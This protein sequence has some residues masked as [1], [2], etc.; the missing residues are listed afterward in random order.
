MAVQLDEAQAVLLEPGTGQ[1]LARPELLVTE[2]DRV[3]PAGAA[4][5]FHRQHSDA[6]FVLEGEVVF[7]LAGEPV[8]A[9]AGTFVLS[10][11]GAVHGFRPPE[12]RFLNFHAP[13]A[14]YFGRGDTF[15][16]PS[17]VDAA[18]PI[19]L[20]PGGG[21]RLL[22][23]ERVAIVKAGLPELT[24]SV[25]EVSPDFEGPEPHQHDDHIDSFYVLDGEI[26]FRVE[27]QTVRAG[28]GFFAAL[29]PGTVHTFTRP[30]ANGARLLNMHAP[31]A[32]FLDFLRAESSQA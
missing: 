2:L 20:A 9:G 19:V 26:E 31:D 21:E 12:G 4:Q 15:D 23:D 5:H 7:E 16:P 25:F 30:G 14:P 10:P 22:G 11:P 32:S 8:P 17:D 29:L 3:P 6:F 18:D 13:G 1:K 24:L 27:D 28:P